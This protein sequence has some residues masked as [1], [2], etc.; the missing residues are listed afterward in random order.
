LLFFVALFFPTA[1]WGRQPPAGSPPTDLEQR[2]RELEETVRRL[3]AERSAAPA[4]ATATDVLQ[5]NPP[6]PP[7]RSA[8]QDTSAVPQTGAGG[9]FPGAPRNP[10]PNPGG[11]GIGAGSASGFGGSTRGEQPLAGWDSEKQYFVLRS[12]DG[13]FSLRITGQ[14]QGDYRGFLHGPDSTDVDSFL[15]RRARLGIEADVLKV[16]E[17]RLLPD[18]SNA[19][20]VL[21]PTASE[22]IQD[23]YLNV[24][25]WDA[26]QVEAGK[27]KQPFGY[28]QLVQDRFVPTMERS[29]IDQLVP[30]RDVGVMVHGQRLLGNRLDYAL[31]VSTGEIN[32][33]YDTNKQKDLVGR[34]VVRPL[35]R[36]DDWEVVR[37]L[38]IGVSGSTGVE[39]E[40]IVPNPLRTPATVPW[41]TFNTGTRL[42]GR[43]DRWSPEVSYFY[44]GFGFA[45]QYLEEYERVSPAQSGT[46]P[47]S[48]ATVPFRGYYVLATYLLTGEERTTYSMPIR[49]RNN[50]DPCRPLACPGAWELVARVSRLAVGDEAFEPLPTGP[51]TSASPA[52]RLGNSNA[53]TELTLGFNWY[54]NPFVRMQF[55]WEHAWFSQP[56]QLGQ[57]TGGLLTHQDTLMTRLQVIF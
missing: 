26:F 31:A 25:W 2:V 55:N 57:G 51:T 11:A 10:T 53:A 27:F 48:V 52:N 36:E 20:S 29:L 8:L 12:Q 9:G 32:G 43:R 13:N 28:E 34:V 22:R 23:A 16:F 21:S 30:A 54:L 50:F 18:F 46:G 3:Q 33:D 1:A 24:H 37:Y 5:A 17:F 44:R 45:A 15:V 7:D 35:Y 4:A 49:P 6:A 42:N 40:A 39:G 41:L 47:S 38:Q 19:Q 56:V 14:V